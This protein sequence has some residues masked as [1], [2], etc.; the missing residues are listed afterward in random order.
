MLFSSFIYVHLHS[1]LPT[2]LLLH[3]PV[4]HAHIHSSIIRWLKPSTFNSVLS[5]SPNKFPSFM[6]KQILHSPDILLTQT[7]PNCSLSLQRALWM[8]SWLGPPWQQP[9]PDDDKQ[10]QCDISPFFMH[11]NSSSIKSPLSLGLERETL[12]LL[13]PCVVRIIWLP[14]NLTVPVLRSTWLLPLVL[15]TQMKGLFNFRQLSPMVKAF[16]L[17]VAPS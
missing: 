9:S 15:L 12:M 11:S 16:T 10:W 8:G 1:K 13:D 14:C 2:L 3:C 6:L 17:H 7:W 4:L 5:P